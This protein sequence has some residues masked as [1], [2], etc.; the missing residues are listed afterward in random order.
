[1][2]KYNCFTSRINFATAIMLDKESEKG[3]QNIRYK[4]LQWKNKVSFNAFNSISDNL[5]L[6]QLMD[7]IAKCQSRSGYSCKMDIWFKLRKSFDVIGR[8]FG[9]L[10]LIFRQRKQNA[11]FDEVLY[12]VRK[13]NPK[14]N[15]R[16]IMRSIFSYMDKKVLK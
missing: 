6:F 16:E 7:S 10:I 1:M 11:L 2:C 15:L 8:I 4:F 12:S 5:I 13:V 9:C 3:E 14:S